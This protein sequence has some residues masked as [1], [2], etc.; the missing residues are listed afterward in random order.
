MGIRDRGSS[1]GFLEK[2]MDRSVAFDIW[3]LAVLA[4]DA[5]LLQQAGTFST[6]S[7]M[8]FPPATLE[9]AAAQA[10]AVTLLAK[11]VNGYLD[12]KE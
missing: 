12:S 11:L 1:S 3:V 6:S 2:F 9:M 7:I 5:Y 8:E 10:T 4:V